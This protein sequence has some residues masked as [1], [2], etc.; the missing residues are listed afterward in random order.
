[1]LNHSWLTEAR[2][3]GGGEGDNWNF[4]KCANHLHMGSS[5]ITIM[6]IST[7]SFPGWISLSLSRSVLTAIFQVNLG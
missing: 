5:Q 4:E 6:N 7:V 3:D 2:D 1:M